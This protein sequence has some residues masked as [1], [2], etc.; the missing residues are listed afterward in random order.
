[1]DAARKA[2]ASIPL[3]DLTLFD[4]R[5][6]DLCFNCKHP[7]HGKGCTQPLRGKKL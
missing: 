6:A 7:F 4:C 3:D 2:V 1:V 5:S